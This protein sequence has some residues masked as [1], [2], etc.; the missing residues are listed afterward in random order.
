MVKLDTVKARNGDLYTSQPLVA[1]FVGAT[2]GIGTY[3]YKTLARLASEGRGLRA[4]IVGRNENQAESIIEECRQANPQGDFRFVKAH[5]IALLQ[6]VDRVCAEITSLEDGE[7]QK[8]GGKPHIDL[9]VMTAAYLAFEGR[10][11]GV[12]LLDQI[13]DDIKNKTNFP[14]LTET[15]EGVDTLLSLLYYSRMRFIERLIPLLQASTLPAHV[16]SVFGPQRDETLHLDDLSLRDPKHYG[17]SSMGSHAAYFKTFYFEHLAA[18][19]PTVAF[20]HYYPSLVIT[21]AFK[22]KGTNAWFKVLWTFIGPFAALGALD[23]EECAQRVLFLASNRFPA[24]DEKATGEKLDGVEVAESSDGVRGGGAYR[25]NWN[26]EIIPVK[27]N[28]EQLRGNGWGE[29]VVAHTQE[30]FRSVDAGLQFQN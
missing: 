19:Y 3:T 1:V 9:L 26:G 16:I 2:S 21:P 22:G 24:R 4:Y 13:N 27:K 6:D 18:K 12:I 5:D 11:G 10:K 20:I 17:F 7:A 8:S 15:S 29:K 28:Y 14:P 30:V 25:V 23:Q